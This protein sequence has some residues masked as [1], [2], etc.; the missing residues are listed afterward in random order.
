MTE[1]RPVGWERI[2]ADWW[3]AIAASLP[4]PW[5]REAVCMDLRWWRGQEA[6]QGRKLMPARRPLQER[7]GWK[8]WDTRMILREEAAWSDPQKLSQTPP[9][10]L[11]NSSQSSPN[12]ATANAENQVESSQ[13]SPKILPELSQ[14]PPSRDPCSQ[15]TE[16]RSQITDP[17]SPSSLSTE[18][19]PSKR[20]RAQSPV[21]EG[22][23]KEQEDSEPLSLYQLFGPAIASAL[24]KANIGDIPALTQRTTRQVRMT[25]GIGESHV[26][27]IRLR[28][29]AMGLDFAEE[30]RVAATGATDSASPEIKKRDFNPQPPRKPHDKSGKP[31]IAASS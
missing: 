23:K 5:P 26:A 31:S 16:H 27:T 28:L 22:L 20:E 2:E 29:Q 12:P 7:W 15:N 24:V 11:P 13:D 3:P 17:L 14:N 6:A 8:E 21:S 25:K 1:F 30:G 10:L 9:K 4:R 18:Q 19:L